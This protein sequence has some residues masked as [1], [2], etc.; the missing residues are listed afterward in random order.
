M[1][2]WNLRYLLLLGSFVGTQ[3]G[4]AQSGEA[5]SNDPDITKYQAVI[6]Q[7][8]QCKEAQY[9]L[10]R[11]DS[12]NFRGPPDA[13]FDKDCIAPLEEAFAMFVN[14]HSHETPEQIQQALA[15][16]RVGRYLLARMALFHAMT[17]QSN[18]K[19][20]SMIKG[21]R[22]MAVQ[23]DSE[24]D[25]IAL[26]NGDE[27]PKPVAITAEDTEVQ[28]ELN[29]DPNEL[30]RDVRKALNGSMV[31]AVL[32]SGEDQSRSTSFELTK[33]KTKM[34]KGG[35]ILSSWANVTKSK[36]ISLFN[37]PTPTSVIVFEV[38]HGTE[39]IGVGNRVVGKVVNPVT[40]T[41]SNL[42]QYTG[43]KAGAVNAAIN[44][45]VV[46]TDIMEKLKQW[47]Q[48]LQLNCALSGS[49]VLMPP[50]GYEQKKGATVLTVDG[51][52]IFYSKNAIVV[53]P[54]IPLRY[55]YDKINEPEG[56]ML[57]GF[58]IEAYAPATKKGDSRKLVMFYGVPLKN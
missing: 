32:G 49:N 43:Y 58:P 25:L 41:I 51:Y 48:P 6:K 44:P 57:W 24:L 9:R 46:R 22:L 38:L 33:E 47:P 12:D 3:T 16:S 7:A 55:R 28:E 8:K 35:S 34:F 29:Q 17:T 39:D 45:T 42:S 36:P 4:F 37:I 26:L 5:P 30:R 23:T 20:D 15:A 53:K 40:L 52:R 50:D 31:A 2:K 27:F 19:N 1:K 11:D 14:S 10:G 56:P 18:G 54:G 21:S 13:T